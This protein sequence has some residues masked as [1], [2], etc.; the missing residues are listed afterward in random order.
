LTDDLTITLT[1]HDEPDALVSGTL[2][3]L[4]RQQGVRAGIDFY[5][6][7]ASPGLAGLCAELSTPALRFRAHPIGKT[8]LSR[9]RNLALENCP[10]ELLLY[11]DADARPRP[12]WAAALA[13]A[14]SGEGVAVAGSRILPDW[15]VRPLFPARSAIVREQYSLLDLGAEVFA[16]DRVIGAGFELDRSKLGAE[17]R[18]DEN[19]GRR[20]GALFGGEETDLCRRAI[21]AGFSVVYCGAAVVDHFV[22]AERITW[23]WLT[24]RFYYA[25]VNRAIAKGPP[26][27]ANRPS[28][29]NI[30]PL[31]P[32]LPVYLFG[33]L[34]ATFGT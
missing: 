18:F 11:L 33:Y 26:R 22:P 14:L 1:R 7:Q 27:P 8:G 21:E 12:G 25:G 9:A 28:L 29:A 16:I 2:R 24:R 15:E 30:L 31:V 10:T 19:L 3:C 6:Q 20:D 34:R 23:R 13:R 17:A 4:A 5:D 32:L